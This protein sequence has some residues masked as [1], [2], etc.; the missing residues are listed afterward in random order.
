MNRFNR[1][2]VLSMIEMA[3]SSLDTAQDYIDLSHEG[4]TEEE[5]CKLTSI[6]SNI[7]ISL[8]ILQTLKNKVLKD[9]ED[10]S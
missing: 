1:M 9:V 7:D 6:L 2:Q 8:D 3:Y 5:S 4:L 10:N